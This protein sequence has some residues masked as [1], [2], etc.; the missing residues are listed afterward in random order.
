M[1]NIRLFRTTNGKVQEIKGE[2]A[3]LEK[4]LQVQFER[5]LLDFLGVTFLASEYST[6]KTHGGRIDSLGIDENNCPVIVEYKKAINE[7]V[8][9]QGLFYLNW[10]QDHREAFELLVL[11]KLGRNKS[12]EIFWDSPRLICIA[13]DF[14]KYDKHAVE[15]IN[16]NIDLIRYKRFGDDLIMLEHINSSIADSSPAV[17]S[18]GKYKTV[19]EQLET[20]DQEM[21]DLFEALRTMLMGFGDDVQMKEMKYYFAFKRLSNFACVEIKN[22]AKKLLVYV[23]VDPESIQLEEGFTRDVRRIGHYGTGDLE[24]TIKSTHDISKARELLQMSYDNS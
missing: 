17:P 5:N 12:K 22:Q 19:G 9:N 4:S 16:A 13:G 18:L 3:P 11:E 10:L 6:G 7:N 1:A 2:S 20:A 8:I 14:T 23:K 21:K 24:I 15:Q